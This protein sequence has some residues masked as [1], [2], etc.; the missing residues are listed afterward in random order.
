MSISELSLI[1]CINY[2]KI[3]HESARIM[4]E[5]IFELPLV[6]SVKLTKDL[7]TPPN[8][9]YIE[10]PLRYASITPCLI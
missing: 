10:A 5:I 6:K 4:H 2:A 3:R 7:S 9:L 1:E 8:D